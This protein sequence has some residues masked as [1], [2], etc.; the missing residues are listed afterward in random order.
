MSPT[1]ALCSDWNLS[2]TPVI[3]D[4]ASFA[5]Q[6]DLKIPHNQGNNDLV[7]AEEQLLVARESLRDLGV[8]FPHIFMYLTVK[9][10]SGPA[11][12]NCTDLYNIIIKKRKQFKFNVSFELMKTFNLL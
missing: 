8:L 1:E 3:R 4:G 7:L 5:W 2:Y 12:L 11:C 10:S 6:S 9:F